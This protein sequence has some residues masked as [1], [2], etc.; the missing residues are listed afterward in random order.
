MEWRVHIKQRCVF[1]AF[2][3]QSERILVKSYLKALMYFITKFVSDSKRKIVW[4][5]EFWFVF[6]DNYFYFTGS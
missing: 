4:E 6:V 5:N 3:A 1:Q 2:F